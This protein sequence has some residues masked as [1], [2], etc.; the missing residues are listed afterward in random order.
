[1]PGLTYVGRLDYMTEGVLLLTTDG[2]AAHRLTHPSVGVERTYVATVRGDAVGAARIARTGV[3]LGDGEIV[4][5]T[6]VTARPMGQR[7]W[8]LEITITEGKHHE[9]RRMCEALNLDIERLVRTR[10]GP[11]KLGNLPAGGNRPLTAAERQALG[12]ITSA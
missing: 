7:R 4:L 2:T 10:F 1:V 9:V 6:D 8:E 3:A 11:V 5:P 12:A